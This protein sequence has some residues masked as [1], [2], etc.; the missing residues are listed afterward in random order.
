MHRSDPELNP[1]EVQVFGVRKSPATRGALR[2]FAEP[3]R[4]FGSPVKD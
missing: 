2:F 1:V 3:L 4:V